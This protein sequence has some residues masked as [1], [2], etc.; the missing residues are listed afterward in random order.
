MKIVVKNTGLTCETA[1]AHEDDRMSA[2]V[3][4]TTYMVEGA[5]HSQAYK[6]GVWDGKER[7]V[8]KISRHE[9]AVPVGLLEQLLDTF[10]FA[11]VID[12]RRVGAKP[13]DLELNPN[14]IEELRLYQQEAVDVVTK[15]RG[16]LTGKGLLRLPTRSGKTVIAAAIIVRTGVR[17]LFIVNSDLLLQQTVKFFEA[18]IRLRSRKGKANRAAAR[19]LIGQYGGGEHD[20]TAHITVAS[21][22]GLIA[23][24]GAGEVRTLLAKTQCVFFDECHHLEAPTWRIVMARCDAFYKIGL[25]ATI[26]LNRTGGTAKGTIWLVGST[27]PV[28]YSLTPSEL[29][30]MGWLNRPVIQ[31]LRSPPPCEPI[32]RDAIFATQYKQGITQNWGR[33]RI[34]ARLAA[35]EVAAGRRPLVTVRHIVHTEELDRMMRLIGLRVSVVTGKTKQADRTDL[36]D[37]VRDGRADVLLGTVF[38]EAVDLPWLQTV[39]VA[40]GLASRTLTMQRL[41][42]L[43][44]IDEGGKVLRKPRIPA[45]EVPVYDFADVGVP[46]L[47]KHSQQRLKAYLENEAFAVRWDE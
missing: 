1:T 25:S 39:I 5:W 12:E 4:A 32:K 38:G 24:A 37:A 45:A 41:R 17:S 9:W 42:N 40:D 23:G 22:Q 6:D 21:V 31:F 47:A 14:I 10:E 35:R 26:Y 15:D 46:L 27:G 44:P 30:D 16:V 29:I 8:E 28:L 36:C 11:T 3:R 20:T 43:T 33:N 2:F 7:L 13:A 18:V 34:I 19:H